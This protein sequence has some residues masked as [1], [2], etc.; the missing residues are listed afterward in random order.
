MHVCCNHFS[1]TIWKVP[2]TAYGNATRSSDARSCDRLHELHQLQGGQGGFNPC[3]RMMLRQSHAESAGLGLENPASSGWRGCIAPFSQKGNGG[4]YC[5]R[6][7]GEQHQQTL[8]RYFLI[9]SCGCLISVPSS[10]LDSHALVP[11]APLFV[12]SADP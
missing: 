4:G 8:L 10:L 2:Y 9:W 7:K 6:R 3:I 5:A 1:E 12:A 11:P